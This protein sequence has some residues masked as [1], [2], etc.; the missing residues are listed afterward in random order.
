MAPGV[1]LGHNGENDFYMCLYWEKIFF[2]RISWQ[3]SIRPDTN[4]PCIMEIQV[5]TNKG[6]GHLQR[7]DIAKIGWCHSIFFS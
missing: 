7:G 5:Y 2:S 6:P 1:G 3:I 4:H